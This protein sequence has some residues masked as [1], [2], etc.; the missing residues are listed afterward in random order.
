MNFTPRVL[1]AYERIDNPRL[2]SIV[3][4]LIKHLH[5]CVKELVLATRNSSLPGTSWGGWRP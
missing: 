1:T 3:S 5:A 2:R 4:S